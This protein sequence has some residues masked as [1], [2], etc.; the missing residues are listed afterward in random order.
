[1]E[2]SGPSSVPLL[3]P[4]PSSQ[5]GRPQAFLVAMVLS[6]GISVHIGFNIAAPNSFDKDL[7]IDLQL[8]KSMWEVLS[9]AFP[10]GGLLGHLVTASGR[11]ETS[12]IRID[13]NIALLLFFTASAISALNETWFWFAFGRF[14]AG[15]AAGMSVVIAPLYI[16]KWPLVEFQHF[17]HSTHQVS[18]AAGMAL[19]YAL[20][21]SLVSTSKFAWQKVYLCSGCCSVF[22]FACLIVAQASN[23]LSR[24]TYGSYVSFINLDQSK[25][26][27]NTQAS[28]SAHATRNRIFVLDKS[29]LVSSVLLFSVHFSG[30][31]GLFYYSTFVF[32]QSGFSNA[33]LISF[34]LGLIHVASTLLSISTSQSRHRLYL[35]NGAHF[36]MA[37]CLAAIPWALA[38]RHWIAICLASIAIVASDVGPAST[39]WFIV[40][41]ITKNQV[42]GFIVLIGVALHWIATWIIVAIIPL[43]YSVAGP[44]LFIFFAIVAFA[45]ALFS[46]Q[47]LSPMLYRYE[48]SVSDMPQS[49]D[50]EAGTSSN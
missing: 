30:V 33:S 11:S 40:A 6:L 9:M 41:D 27:H 49:S 13:F 43:M 50:S 3:R 24:Q 23:I 20:S 35:L 22:A 21:L 31:E 10:A 39:I 47:V 7:V 25:T 45:S 36:V 2:N 42:H 29:M 44:Y 18:I 32:R 17:L 46:L 26:S 48:S 38:S 1:M 14:I 34:C 15:F 5:P 37:I 12:D 28:N 19:A 16:S 4:K 8:H